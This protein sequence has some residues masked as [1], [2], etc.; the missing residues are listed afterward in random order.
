MSNDNSCRDIDK[1]LDRDICSDFGSDFDTDIGRDIGRDFGAE[2]QLCRR[3]VEER[4]SRCFE[5]DAEY[6]TLL[7]SMR[8]SL[9]AGG[10]RIR[11]V[12]CMKFCEA[13]G[14]S[15][16]DALDAACAIE[17]LHAYSL[18]HDDLPCMDDD[19][20]RRGLPSN[21]IKYGE[22]TA[23]L[24]GDALQAASFGTLLGSDLPPSA[25]VEM[26]RELAKAAGPDGICGGQYLDLRGAGEALSQGNLVEINDLKTAA[27]ISASARIGVI[28][29]GGSPA[30]QDAADRYARA[31]GLAFQIR[32]D[33]LDITSTDD[34][35]G[36]PA[37]SDSK[38]GK[39]TFATLLGDQECERVIREET[40]SAIAALEGAFDDSRFHAWL[41][42]ELSH[43]LS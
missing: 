6:K 29:A 4:L 27:L 5:G 30:Q 33:L 11:A 7:D 23:T 9:L 19:D 20:L 39:T 21:H 25:V 2:L 42:H 31:V 3:L 13:A 41:A 28:A 32:D 1:D 35:L 12:I 14:G 24:A 34:E 10:K 36:K 26:A 43:R 17:M 16:E 8:Y 40:E 38:S 15:I 37:G 22:F 18:I